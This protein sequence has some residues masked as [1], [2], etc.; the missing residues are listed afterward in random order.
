[1]VDVVPADPGLNLL[2]LGQLISMSM[3]VIER[4]VPIC[5]PVGNLTLQIWN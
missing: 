4:N 3:T 1:M 2:F 5:H